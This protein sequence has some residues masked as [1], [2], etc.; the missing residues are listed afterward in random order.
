MSRL[1]DG[2]VSPAVVS[3]IFSS[4]LLMPG[5]IEVVRAAA[6]RRLACVRACVMEAPQG[7]S[8][9]LNKRPPLQAAG[10]V[11]RFFRGG[12]NPYN[13]CA[14]LASSAS[15]AAWLTRRT[16]SRAQDEGRQPLRHGNGR[17]PC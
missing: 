14:R 5:S 6:G 2:A 10:Y 11:R 7:L 9:K 17:G 8:M 12:D 13:K 3:K 15:A 1:L 4:V 16:P